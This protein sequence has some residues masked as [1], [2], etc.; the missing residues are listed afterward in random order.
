MRIPPV[1]LAL[2]WTLGIAFALQSWVG[3]S[4][5]GQ[6]AL[7]PLS[8]WPLG[9]HPLGIGPDGQMVVARFYPW[10]LLTYAFLHA[11][12][13]HLFFN[14][15]GIVQFGMAV[16]KAWGSRRFAIYFLACVAGAGILQLAVAA[17]RPAVDAHPVIGASGGVYALL[18][19]FAVTF[20]QARM[21]LLIP[22]IP[23][24]AR[25]LVIVFGAISLA[26]GVSGSRDGIAHVVHLGG[27]VIG[28][29]LIKVWKF[30][31]PKSPP[32]MQA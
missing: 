24:R 20:P 12:L 8:L 14:A 2:L 4:I 29:L 17:L 16:E 9:E 27:L 22:P 6:I 10:Q 3:G 23:V 11:D 32:P 7:L 21:M 13:G 30:G 26:Y 19:A 28:W 31:P 15:L 1:T 5:E 25:T 18:L